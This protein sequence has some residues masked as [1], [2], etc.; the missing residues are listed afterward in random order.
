MRPQIA[1]L[2]A[3]PALAVVATSP[4]HAA[5]TKYCHGKV[6]T[7]VGTA[8]R[9]VVNGT[10]TPGVYWLG[11]GND[12]FHGHLGVNLLGGTATGDLVC[13][14]NGN[15]RLI[16]SAQTSYRDLL[17]GG[18]GRDALNGNGG[19]DTVLGGKGN[20]V[21]ADASG[22]EK[23]GGGG[24]TDLLTYVLSPKAVT[25]DGAAATVTGDGTDTYRGV[26]RITGSP[27]ADTMTGGDEAD[28][29]SGGGGADVL[30]GNGGN[31]VLIGRKSQVS[32]GAGDDVLVVVGGTGSG[33]TGADNINLSR[34]AVVHGDA[35]RD[36][37]KLGTGGGT[38]Y[39]DADVDTFGIRSVKA[40]GVVDGGDGI[41]Q[42][43]F[44]GLRVGVRVDLAAGTATFGTHSIG[45][46]RITVVQG[47]AH[48]DRISGSGQGDYLAG[49]AGNDTLLGR[50]GNDLLLGGPGRD[51]GDGGA[52]AD[53]CGTEVKRRCEA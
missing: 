3:V 18:A 47:T 12:V 40:S 50:G 13:G 46:R 15:D 5:T 11:D 37:I 38:A 8:G 9:D 42:I 24:G 19:P 6:A 53:I 14:G 20:D 4:A 35:G 29:F 25:V 21:L 7:Y 44:Q 39:G 2:L 22:D 30:T 36:L 34:G 31:D 51:L 45:L 17:D 26:E 43:T 32:G 27:F 52:G 23:F 49:G 10:S 48:A 41:N 28:W 16:G 33:G 1:L